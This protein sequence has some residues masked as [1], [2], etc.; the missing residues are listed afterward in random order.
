M[1]IQDKI[2]VYR[3]IYRLKD[4]L[5]ITCNFTKTF[6]QMVK[7]TIIRCI[8]ALVVFKSGGLDQLDINS[9]FLH[10][11]LHEDVYI[12]FSVGVTHISPNSICKL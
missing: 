5:V 6:S 3:S 1:C 9:V 11:D 2:E 7:M 10:G 4:W 8:L 12:K